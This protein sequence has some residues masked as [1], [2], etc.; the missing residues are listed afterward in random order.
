MTDRSR[1]LALL[2][3]A[4]L[5]SSC[6]ARGSLVE[7]VAPSGGKLDCP[8]ELVASS[9]AELMDDAVGADSAEAALG[10]LPSLDR[11]KGQSMVEDSNSEEVVFLFADA[12]GNRRGRVGTGR[13]GDRGWFVLWVE[14]CGSD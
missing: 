9:V 1:I 6:A 5:V 4:L 2:A 3:I 13:Q 10:A 14:K 12:D 11:P 7:V 8:D